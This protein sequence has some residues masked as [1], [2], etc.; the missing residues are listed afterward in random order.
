MINQLSIHHIAPYIVEK[1]LS[2]HSYAVPALCQATA[3]KINTHMHVVGKNNLVFLPNFHVHEYKVNPF[4]KFILS[5]KDLKSGLINK[6]KSGDIIHSHGVWR[7]PHIYSLEVLKHKNVKI[8]NSPKGSFSAEALKVSKFKKKIFSSFSKQNKFLST[9]HAFHATSIKEK[10]EI[11]KLGFKQPI[12]VIPEGIDIPKENKKFKNR[13]NIK[14]L[15]L[16]RIHPIKGLDILINSWKKVEE[17]ELNCSLEICGY[18][19]DQEYFNHLLNLVKKNGLQNIHF[20]D[21]VYGESKSKK[22]LDNDI[23]ILPSKSENFALVIAEA[24]SHEMPVITSKNTPWSVVKEKNLGW[25]VN[26]NENDLYA[27]IYESSILPNGQ[28]NEM[29]ISGKKYIKEHF[30][31]DVLSNDYVKFYKWVQNGGETPVFVDIL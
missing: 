25:F 18:Y 28:I 21:K 6:T 29:G 27:A 23:F 14:Y 30:S 10:D 24:M 31:W 13:K 2:G 11:R 1:Q 5:S 16:G 7:M 19:D 22:Y 8:I 12:A 17:N 20:G 9:C 3:N 4:L 26:S 15:Y